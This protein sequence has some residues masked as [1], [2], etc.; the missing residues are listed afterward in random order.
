MNFYEYST[1]ASRTSGSVESNF[2]TKLF[3]G[4]SLKFSA[5]IFLEYFSS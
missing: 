5:N 2:S 3:L 4:D 1:R